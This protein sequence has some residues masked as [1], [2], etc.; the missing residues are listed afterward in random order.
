MGPSLYLHDP[1]DNV[2]ELKGPGDGSRSG[3]L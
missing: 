3:T 1:E 2:V